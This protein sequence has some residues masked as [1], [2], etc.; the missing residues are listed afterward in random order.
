MSKAPPPV[1][2]FG[3]QVPLI[4]K[5]QQ[6]AQA[7]VLQLV[8]QLST[9]IYVQ[10]AAAYIGTRYDHQE[11]DVDRLK[12]FA[13]DAHTAGQAFVEGLGIATFR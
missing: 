5:R 1:P 2:P 13:R 4:G 10:I 12:R 6:Q 8:Q 9:G 3:Q 11:V 7:Q